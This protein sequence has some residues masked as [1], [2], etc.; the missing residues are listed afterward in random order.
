MDRSQLAF[1]TIIRGKNSD[2]DFMLFGGPIVY[3][4]S[5]EF[6]QE[7]CDMYMPFLVVE[8]LLQSIITDSDS[9]ENIFYNQGR[10]N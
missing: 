8:G 6:A 9:E 1:S 7:W 5:W 3:A 4:P 2:G 10:L